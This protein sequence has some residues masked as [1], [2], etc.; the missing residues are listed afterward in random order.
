MNQLKD[1]QMVNHFLNGRELTTKA[2]LLKNVKRLH[3]YE[4]EDPDSFFP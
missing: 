1:H 4:S 3:W 2:G